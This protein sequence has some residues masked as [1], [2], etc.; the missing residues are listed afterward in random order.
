MTEN[1]KS[2]TT[3]VNPINREL[4]AA[5]M[6]KTTF[7]KRPASTPF[8]GLYAGTSDKQFLLLTALDRPIMHGV[9]LAQWRLFVNAKQTLHKVKAGRYQWLIDVITFIGV[10][11]KKIFPVEQLQ[12]L[13][14]NFLTPKMEAHIYKRSVETHGVHS[15]DVRQINLEKVVN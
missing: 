1:L 8:N 15:P 3:P 7:S 13:V 12:N 6:A 4:S 14:L 5:F 9:V 10:L 11:H 2:H